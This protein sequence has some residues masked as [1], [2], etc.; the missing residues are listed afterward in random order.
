VKCCVAVPSLD[1]IEVEECRPLWG[2][3]V[4]A[5]AIP[6]EVQDF[7]GRGRLFASVALA[8]GNSHSFMLGGPIDGFKDCKRPDT[9]L[10]LGPETSEHR[11]SVLRILRCE[12]YKPR[13]QRLGAVRAGILPSTLL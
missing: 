7:A 12:R 6:P 11:P 8:N 2:T 4:L 5:A 1:P 3:R 13:Y 9:W 10:C